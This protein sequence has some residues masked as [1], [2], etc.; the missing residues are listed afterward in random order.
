MKFLI[1]GLKP[2][3]QALPEERPAS[4][5]PTTSTGSSA[6]STCA[7]CDLRARGRVTLA[8]HACGVHHQVCA[9]SMP[10]YVRQ[11]E[12]ASTSVRACILCTPRHL[13]SL[14]LIVHARTTLQ[15]GTPSRT[16]CAPRTASTTTR[17]ERTAL[18]LHAV[19]AVFRCSAATLEGRVLHTQSLVFACCHTLEP[20]CA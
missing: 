4:T 13:R 6:S 8:H 15:I 18:S 11:R 9:A 12:K 10:T 17:C 7:V 5:S 19:T 14:R 3:P 16:F 1:R 2:P 20:K